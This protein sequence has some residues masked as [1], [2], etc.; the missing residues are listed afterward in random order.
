MNANKAFARSR[1]GLRFLFSRKTCVLLSL[2]LPQAG[3][4]QTP[5]AEA[6]PAPDAM[7]VQPDPTEFFGRADSV[8]M[9]QGSP[10]RFGGIGVPWLGLVQPP[11][12][13]PRFPTRYETDDIFTTVATMD[14]G[15]VRAAS[16]GLTAGCA[17]CMVPSPGTI[18]PDALHHIDTILREARDAGLK[19]IIPLTGIADCAAAEPP[20]GAPPGQPPEQPEPTNDPVAASPCAF[21][22]FRHVDGAAFYTDAAVRADFAAAVTRLL[23]H[24]NPRTGIALKD[25]PTILAWENCDACGH[26]IDPKI[27]ADWTEFLGRTIKAI[28][29]HHLYENGAF[30]GRLGKV[31]GAVPSALIALPSVDIVGDRVMPGTDPTGGAVDAAA[32]QVTR[33]NR[34]FLIDAYGWSPAQWATADDFQAFLKSIAKNREIAGAFLANLSGHADTGGYL[35]PGPANSPAGVALYFPGVT[36]PAANYTEMTARARAV[37]RL[38]FGMTD[39][40]TLPFPN[41]NQPEIISARHGHVIWRG[42]AGATVYSIARSQNI[43][44]GGS[45]TTLCDKCVTDAQGS[46]QDP[47]PLNTPVWYR[48][49]P[50]NANDHSGLY[51][52]PVKGN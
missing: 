25:D 21:T 6:L 8:L 24:L 27:L 43:S 37:R 12:E 49:L 14:A 4:A 34:I 46:W 3:H 2:L 7:A 11:G 32:D 18:N 28:D 48:I 10:R 31:A 13:P 33:S 38:S 36:T 19:L 44:L 16:L 41:V 9:L 39:M 50:F 40:L 42:A 15:I 22:G 47:S 52:D 1:Q 23:N 20:A 51:S 17:A 45:W 5:N 29:T 35:P 26:G 30:T